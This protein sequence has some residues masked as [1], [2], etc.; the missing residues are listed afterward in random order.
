MFVRHTSGSVASATVDMTYVYRLLSL[1]YPSNVSSTRLGI[2]C[3]VIAKFHY[4]DTDTDPNEPARTQRSFAAKKSV[5]VQWNLAIIQRTL[6]QPARR[7]RSTCGLILCCSISFVFTRNSVTY[8][9]RTALRAMSVRILSTTRTNCT[10][11][12]QH[13]EAVRHVDRHV[14]NSHDTSIVLQVSSASS[15]VVVFLLTTRSTCRGEIFQ[16]PALEQSFRGK[17]LKFRM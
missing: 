15:T 13:I 5:S 16:V 3:F 11:N 8:P 7:R 2:R 14:V 17:Q 12:A 6:Y 9:R 4:T 1:R 10:T